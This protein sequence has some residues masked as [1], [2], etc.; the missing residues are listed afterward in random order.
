MGDHWESVGSALH[1]CVDRNMSNVP[2][3][4]T[5]EKSA[6]INGVLYLKQ[7]GQIVPR[8]ESN[9]FHLYPIGVR[10]KINKGTLCTLMESKDTR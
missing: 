3:L 8:K 7:W 4:D 10:L 9:T 2:N 1:R 5:F 6:L